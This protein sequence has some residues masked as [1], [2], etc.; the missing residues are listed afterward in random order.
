MVIQANE[1]RFN[2]CGLLKWHEAGYKG[3]GIRIAVFDERPYI[4]AD[5]ESYAQIPQGVKA[6]SPSH[7]TRV[8]KCLHEAAPAA[9]IFMLSACTEDS[10]ANVDW[11][12]ANNIDLISC[13]YIPPFADENRRPYKELK[14]SGIP[15]IISSG[16]EGQEGLATLPAFSWTVA[17]GAAEYNDTKTSY[18]N[19]G[20]A[21]DCLA[22]IPYIELDGNIFAPSGTSFAQPMAAGMVACY[23]GATGRRG[24]A[25]VADFIVHNCRDIYEQ[26]K[27]KMS[28]YGVLTMPDELP[29][30]GGNNMI[31]EYQYPFKSRFVF[32]TKYGV[33]GTSWKCGWHSGIDLKSTNYGGDGRVYPIAAGVV[34]EIDNAGSYGKHIYILH[35]DGYLSLYAHL[36]KIN[37]TQGQ[38]VDLNTVIGQE[39]TTGNSTGIHL[40]LEVHKGSYHYPASIDPFEF[41]EQKI[42]EAEEA[43][44]KAQIEQIVQETVKQILPVLIEELEAAK[45]EKPVSSWAAEAWKIATN[46]K[47]FD[48]S[49]PQS[50]ITREQVAVV[51]NRLGVI[52]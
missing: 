19:Y 24:R 23:M 2:K 21:L 18:T 37:V 39:G 9:Q 11:I 29:Q 6:D 43:M 28:G 8:A 47:A 14:D 12:I 15:F 30:Q 31:I 49:M 36:S 13:S 52:R 1:Q 50:P 5:M 32:G 51:L 48:G 16:N 34:Q 35:D 38:R 3:A 40:H 44:E 22:Y 26:G 7:A 17:V 20:A 33:K 10:A 46:R 4:T 25:A 41:L 27:D 42:K 45:R